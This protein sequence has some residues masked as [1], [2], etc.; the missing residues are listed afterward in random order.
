MN[1]NCLSFVQF[2]R[3][4]FMLKFGPPKNV[5]L[6]NTGQLKLFYLSNSI[7]NAL[8]QSHKMSN[9]SDIAFLLAG[10]VQQQRTTTLRVCLGPPLTLAHAQCNIFSNRNFSILL[11]M[12]DFSKSNKNSIFPWLFLISFKSLTNQSLISAE[13]TIVLC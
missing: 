11:L 12:E 8:C 1:A 5:H 6:Q 3:Q 9:Y 7:F 2:V 10:C 13:E 4:R